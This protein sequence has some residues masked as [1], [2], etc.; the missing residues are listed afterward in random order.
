[1][2]SVTR[3]NREKNNKK[4]TAWLSRAGKMPCMAYRPSNRPLPDKV[5]EYF[6]MKPYGGIYEQATT[7]TASQTGAVRTEV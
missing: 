5:K 3:R 4:F 7:K 6:K 2:S 1:M